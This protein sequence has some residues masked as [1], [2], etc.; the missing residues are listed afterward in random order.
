[1][2]AVEKWRVG[3]KGVKE[4][5]GR[6]EWTTVKYTHSGVTLRNPSEHQLNINNEDR[7]VK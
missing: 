5:N 4:S 7:T 6:V 1:L 3:G 2:K